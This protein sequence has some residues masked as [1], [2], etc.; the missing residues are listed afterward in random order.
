MDSPENKKIKSKDITKI[1]KRIGKSKNNFKKA[2]V[3]LSKEEIKNRIE[4]SIQKIDDESSTLSTNEKIRYGKIG[5][6]FIKGSE[7]YFLEFIS[8]IKK[9]ERKKLREKNNKFDFKVIEKEKNS[10]NEKK[11]KGKINFGIKLALFGA[12]FTGVA[13]TIKNVYDYISNNEKIINIVKELKEFLPSSLKFRS[14]SSKFF[15]GKSFSFVL[16]TKNGEEVPISDVSFSKNPIEESAKSFDDI[17]LT[18]FLKDGF[19]NFANNLNENSLIGY[20]LFKPFTVYVNKANEYLY[21]AIR[22]PKIGKMYRDTIPFLRHLMWGD[23]RNFFEGELFNKKYVGRY[24]NLILKSQNKETELIAN[25]SNTLRGVLKNKTDEELKKDK[26]VF[27][28]KRQIFNGTEGFEIGTLSG[29]KVTDLIEK[30]IKTQSAEKV[31]SVINEMKSGIKIEKTKNENKSGGLITGWLHITLGASIKVP[32]NLKE[33]LKSSEGDAIYVKGNYKMGGRFRYDYMEENEKTLKK[34]LK[35][36]ED[37]INSTLKDVSKLIPTLFAHQRLNQYYSKQDSLVKIMSKNNLDYVKQYESVHGDL[38]YFDKNYRTHEKLSFF[39][40][41]YFDG[42]WKYKNFIHKFLLM[43]GDNTETAY[44]QIHNVINSFKSSISPYS[45]IRETLSDVDKKDDFGNNIRDFFKKST[46]IMGQSSEDK[47]HLEVSPTSLFNI[48][49]NYSKSKLNF[50]RV[51][52]ELMKRLLDKT[53]S[54]VESISVY[55]GPGLTS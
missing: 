3:F 1:L 9:E 5:S 54:T 50:R 4:A 22:D 47:T 14:G 46:I 53:T 34:N 49:L 55:F 40:N 13:Y 48:L 51:R 45:Y 25:I 16:S 20:F 2:N 15:D 30:Y 29:D 44:T 43:M 17:F 36:H 38:I 6:S 21:D 32:P 8:K 23:L 52:L 10:F 12:A 41:D 35:L 31:F 24:S 26:G 7:D 11:K 18:K 42:R 27:G 28:H 37:A 19:G 33:M 39:I